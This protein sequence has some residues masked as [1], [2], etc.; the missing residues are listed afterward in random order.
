MS[1]LHHS[2]EKEMP[3]LFHIKVQVK[4]TKVYALFDS[5][6]QANLM[7]EDLMSKLELEA[8]DHPPTS[9]G[10]QLYRVKSY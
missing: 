6:S 2:E 1:N 3:K 10:E 5:G 4:K 7:L 8:H 9:M